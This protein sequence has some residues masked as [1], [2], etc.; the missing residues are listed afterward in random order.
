MLSSPPYSYLARETGTSS[1][2]A[3]RMSEPTPRYLPPKLSTTPAWA[4]LV[5]NAEPNLAGESDRPAPG[6]FLATRV[7]VRLRWSGCETTLISSQS[8][9]NSLPHSR[10]TTQVPDG[11]VA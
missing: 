2:R 3:L 1:Q 5:R 7:R 8:Y 4:G 10:Q 9:R 6:G 11:A